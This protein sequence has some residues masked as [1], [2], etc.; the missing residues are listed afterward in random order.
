KFKNKMLNTLT[1]EERFRGDILSLVEHSD[2][3]ETIAITSIAHRADALY[4]E[5]LWALHQRLALLN[6]G[7]K[8]D[9]RSNPASPVQFSEALRKV[10]AS[11]AVDVKTRIIGYKIFD[12]EI[13][14]KLD[15]LYDEMNHYL[16]AQQL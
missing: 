12:E 10:L 1:G 15:S 6:D 5:P 7:E 8:I 2:L 4:A 11:L 13:I 14:G 9:E 16:I 3:E